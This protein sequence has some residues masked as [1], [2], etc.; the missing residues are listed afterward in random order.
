MSRNLQTVRVL[1]RDANCQLWGIPY[2]MRRDVGQ[3]PRDLQRA[4]RTEGWIWLGSPGWW[5]HMTHAEQVETETFLA[6]VKDQIPG[7]PFEWD[8]LPE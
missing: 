6:R 1:Y 5:G 8:E 2:L 7:N 4:G 3:Q